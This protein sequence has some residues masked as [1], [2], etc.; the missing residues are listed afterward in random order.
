MYYVKKRIEV[1]LAH[2]LSLPYESKC[3]QLHGHNAIITVYCRSEK[4]NEYGMVVDFKQLKNII[5]NMLDHRY[6][7]EV[8]DFN[9]TAE[10]LAC[11]I[12]NNI[13]HCYKVS[14]QETEGNVACY[15]KDG[16]CDVEF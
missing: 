14:F 10:N 11:H 2:K 6:I 16:E 4:L 9:P 13:E 5:E 1:S 8:V 15:V 7:N 12:C 3:T